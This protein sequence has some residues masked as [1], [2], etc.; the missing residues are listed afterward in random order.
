MTDKID[1][2]TI[3]REY[4][5]GSET[6]GQIAVRHG[7]LENT[8]KRHSNRHKWSVKRLEFQARAEA[9]AQ[10]LAI[11]DRAKQLSSFNDDDLKVARALRARV[12]RRLSVQDKELNSGELR[13]LAASAE[14]AQ[15]IGRL[16]LGASTDNFGHGG[17]GGEG[18]VQFKDM[19]GY[20]DEQLDIL[21]RAALLLSGSAFET[22]DRSGESTRQHQS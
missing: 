6:I 5:Q 4:I 15:R 10:T 9:K 18:P 19:A 8:V 2:Q 16:A 3:D 17:P 21:E 13:Q 22:G 11:K 12:A 7:L 1:W 20:S 14:A